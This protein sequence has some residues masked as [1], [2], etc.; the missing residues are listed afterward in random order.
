MEPIIP[1]WLRYIIATIG[2]GVTSAGAIMGMMALSRRRNAEAKSIRTKGTLQVVDSAIALNERLEKENARLHSEVAQLRQA[3]NDLRTE[4]Y[5]LRQRNEHFEALIRR[6]IRRYEGDDALT[7]FERGEHTDD[8]D[9]A[10][11][12][13]LGK[14]Y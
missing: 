10:S 6:L 7:E 8:D 2:A 1:E 12:G 13:I 4:V 5:R 14:M 11:G 3:V 9:D